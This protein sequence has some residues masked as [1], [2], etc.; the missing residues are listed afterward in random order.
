[1]LDPAPFALAEAI[2]DVATLISTRA[3]EKDLELIVRVQPGLADTYVGDVGRIRQ[4]ITNLIGNAVKFTDSGHVLVD[5]S[6]ERQDDGTRIR[7][8]GYRH[9]IGIPADKLAAGVREVQPSGRV[10]DATARRHRARAGD[11]LAPR[12]D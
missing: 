11:H 5:A 3:K 8:S 10:L 2:E 6:G 1:M 7:I 12:A 4:I 9:G